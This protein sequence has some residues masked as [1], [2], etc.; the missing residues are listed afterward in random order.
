MVDEPSLD[1]R[2]CSNPYKPPCDRWR[3][4]SVKGPVRWGPRSPRTS[5]AALI[6]SV[7]G[8]AFES[9]IGLGLGLLYVFFGGFVCLLTLLFSGYCLD[10][11]VPFAVIALVVVTGVLAIVLSF[12]AYERSRDPKFT[13]GTILGLSAVSLA[14]IVIVLSSL[15]GLSYS[16]ELEILSP[17]FVLSLIGGV[18]W[19][20]STKRREASEGTL[21]SA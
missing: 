21:F 11:V 1:I 3:E 17:F 4:V 14:G 12:H 2:S 8:G 20:L 18:L 19:I 16:Y 5:L 6:L 7:L 9:L 13:G 10:A 15:G